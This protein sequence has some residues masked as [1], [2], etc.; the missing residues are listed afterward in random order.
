MLRRRV[1]LGL[2]LP[3]I[4]ACGVAFTF[5]LAHAL[6]RLSHGTGGER[7]LATAGSLVFT[8]AGMGL[9]RLS[10]PSRDRISGRA[11]R[12]RLCVGVGIDDFI[13]RVQSGRRGGDPQSAQGRSD[14]LVLRRIASCWRS[15]T[16]L[17]MSVWFF[18]AAS[19]YLNSF[20]RD[21]SFLPH[22]RRASSGAFGCTCLCGFSIA[23]GVI[24]AG[25]LLVFRLHGIAAAGG[26]RAGARYGIVSVAVIADRHRHR[27]LGLLFFRAAGFAPGTD[28]CGVRL[29][30][31][32]PLICRASDFAPKPG[33]RWAV[34]H[35][36]CARL[37]LHRAAA[38]SAARL[39]EGWP[40]LNLVC[41]RCAT[42][43][44]QT[45]VYR[46]PTRCA[47]SLRWRKNSRRTTG[48][49]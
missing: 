39:I 20:D 32:I 3:Q 26:A 31:D 8:L 49:R 4:A 1:F 47:R 16:A 17:F 44:T 35:V 10:G 29:R 37:Q 41:R 38:N 22:R 27:G 21:L 48:P 19:F 24:M 11:V 34:S 9:A 23:V 7:F 36:V 46:A 43:R 30:G 6:G 42:A 33:A 2:T 45:C 13:C 15:F 14:F 40:G 12:R 5:W 25:P 18:F 28:G